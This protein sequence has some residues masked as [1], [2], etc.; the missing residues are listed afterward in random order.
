MIYYFPISLTL[1]RI[2]LAPIFLIFLFWGE[3]YLFL[4]IL[5]FT[6]A[7]LTDFG[8][9]YVARKYNVVTESGIFLDPLADKILIM[10]A[11]FG[12]YFLGII[13]LWM[14]F[15]IATRD[16]LIMMLRTVIFRSGFCMVTSYQA[17]AKTVFQFV[18]IYLIFI[19]L[20]LDFKINSLTL[21]FWLGL[22]VDIVMYFVIGI[23]IWTGISYLI[24][25]KKFI[26]QI[27]KK[28]EG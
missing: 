7:A 1:L 12:F 2:I 25:N 27:F 28:K 19:F 22:S 13:K 8:D 5:V 10:A 15:L 23:T 20:I 11:F 21:N 24:K 3:N 26:I 18:A 6:L 4:A 14:P 9:G 16:I 17:K